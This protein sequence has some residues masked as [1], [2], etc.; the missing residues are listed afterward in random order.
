MGR[1][2]ATE[3]LEAKIEKAQEK[4]VKRK[5]A[6]DEAVDELQVLL[7]KLT[8]IRTDEIMKA[9]AKSSKTY[10]EILGFINA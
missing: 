5:A 1:T 7:D 3:T 8:A 2:V 9:I 10:E 6:Y 4:V